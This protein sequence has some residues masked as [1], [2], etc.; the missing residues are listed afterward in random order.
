LEKYF[1][2]V[3]K[4][5]FLVFGALEKKFWAFCGIE[6]KFFFLKKDFCRSSGENGVKSEKK[7]VFSLQKWLAKEF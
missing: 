6:G 7:V 5:Y 1:C 3:E 2:K 4:K